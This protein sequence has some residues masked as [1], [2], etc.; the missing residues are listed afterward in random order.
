MNWMLVAHRS[1]LAKDGDY[2]LLQAGADQ[3]AAINLEGEIIATDNVCKHRGARVLSG[4]H[5]NGP[6]VCSYHGMKGRATVARQYL[7]AW[8]GDFLFVGDGGSSLDAELGELRAQVE[9]LSTLIDKRHSF[10]MLPMPCDWRVAVEN[11]LEDYHVPT[12][13]PDTFGK[14]GL[15]LTDTERYGKNS[16]A[17]YALTDARTVKS[18][19]ALQRYFEQGKPEHYFH[20][21]LYPHTT[22]SSV[23]GFS[24]SLQHYLPNGGFTMLHSRL[25]AAKASVQAP[26]LGWFYAEAAAFNRTVFAQ[27]SAVCAKV[28]GQG[29]FLTPAEER[30]A[31]FREAAK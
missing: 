19:T 22:L 29:T 3:V 5:G 30:V 11:T 1:E 2:V 17:G 18:L 26:D 28:V 7:T 23:G 10:D 12:V 13:H 6:L 9:F 21:F 16:L 20:I 27:D 25:Y 31:W 24:F 8:V 14:L 4:T 15:K